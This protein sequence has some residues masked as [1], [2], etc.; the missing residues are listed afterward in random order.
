MYEV[1]KFLYLVVKTPNIC[2]W[3]LGNLFLQKEVVG[4][5]FFL[6]NDFPPL[7]ILSLSWSPRKY[8][9]NLTCFSSQKT[10]FIH[11]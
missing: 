10:R 2:G 7:C 4:E 9:E 11:R 6:F 3:I 1:F 5:L 8:Y